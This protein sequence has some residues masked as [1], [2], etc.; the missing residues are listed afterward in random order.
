MA[1]TRLAGLLFGLDLENLEIVSELLVEMVGDGARFI[2]RSPRGDILTGDDRSSSV[3]TRL[4]NAG[5]RVRDL[6]K[7]GSSRLDLGRFPVTMRESK[8]VDADRR[9]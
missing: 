3:S 9:R 8:S 6:R 5:L 7:L 2:L 1:D 4:P